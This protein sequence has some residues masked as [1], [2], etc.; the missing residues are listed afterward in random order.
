MGRTVRGYTS[1]LLFPAARLGEGGTARWEVLFWEVLFSV[2]S[3]ACGE[4]KNISAEWTRDAKWLHD[5]MDVSSCG[6]ALPPLL[7]PRLHPTFSQPSTKRNSV[8]DMASQQ[9]CCPTLPCFS[10]TD[11]KPVDEALAGVLSLRDRVN[12]LLMVLLMI[13]LVMMM[14][15]MMM[16]V[17][18][19]AHRV[20]SD[21]DTHTH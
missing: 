12:A 5:M 16:M 11:P 19:L 9:Y 10:T 20:V 21:G 18:F 8:N 1:V 13:M 17:C 6:A 3:Y 14:M 15:M 2:P 7:L 4:E